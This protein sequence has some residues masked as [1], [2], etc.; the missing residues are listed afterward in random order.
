MT[1][2]LR[3]VDWSDENEVKQ[4][5]VLMMQ[6][7]EIDIADALELLSGDFKNED[8]RQYAVRQLQRADDDELGSYLLQLVQALRYESSPST[9]PLF[10]L[11]V[12]RCTKSY[13]LTNFFHWF[14][15]VEQ[16]DPKRGAMFTLLHE[17]FTEVI[18]S[19]PAGSKWVQE[20]Y[21]QQQLIKNMGT[22]LIKAEQRYR[23]VKPREDYVKKLLKPGGLFHSMT[24][25]SEPVDVPFR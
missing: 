19:T 6:W 8:V 22:L 7:A 25:F 12:A 15:T 1:K 9:G 20:L 4:A 23:K 3:C 11:L 21:R 18:G 5:L 2:F 17:K 10:A 24:K 13:N 14:L 16:A